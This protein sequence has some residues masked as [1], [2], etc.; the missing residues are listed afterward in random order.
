MIEWPEA[1]WPAATYDDVTYLR[2]PPEVEAHHWWT[3]ACARALFT[4]E[5]SFLCKVNYSDV[6][7]AAALIATKFDVRQEYAPNLI[8]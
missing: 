8:Q 2:P 4:N 5:S 3:R 6:K 7:A 1:L